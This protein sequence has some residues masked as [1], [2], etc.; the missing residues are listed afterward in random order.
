VWSLYATR[1]KGENNP[2]NEGTA[3]S[4]KGGRRDAPETNVP[5]SMRK[6]TSIGETNGKRESKFLHLGRK[7]LN[8]GKGGD[9]IQEIVCVSR[10]SCSLVSRTRWKGTSHLSGIHGFN[11]NSRV[12]R[13][14][15]GT[16]RRGYKKKKNESV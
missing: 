11:N 16:K 4:E 6:E 10:E 12:M 13:G 1:K 8:G 15:R 14:W 7:A 9:V 2:I 3:P 5:W